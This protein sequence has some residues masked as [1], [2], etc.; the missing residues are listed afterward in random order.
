MFN[1]TLKRV[2]ASVLVASFA[3]TAIAPVA[4]A[5]FVES[6]GQ[7]KSNK[8]VVTRIVNYSANNRDRLDTLIAAVT[9]SQFDGAIVNTL[10]SADKV[11][12]FAPTNYAFAKLGRQ[13]DRLLDLG[14]GKQGLTAS[15]VCAVDDLLGEG[16][17]ETILTYHVTTPK[18]WYGQ[19]L[20]A[21]GSSIEMLSGEEAALT[22]AFKRVKI[23]G[24]FVR[25][26]NIRSGN[27]ITHVISGVMI[28]PSV[29]AKI[30]D[31]LD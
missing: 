28:P 8:D 20:K 25:V 3:V 19:A 12:V 26:K 22:G 21:R 27:G 18:I 6:K 24:Q 23:D 29:E 11:T 15:N 16:T 31:L 1:G 13:L 30:A 2:M 5:A 9:C 7:I 4:G 10:V 17:L 14:L